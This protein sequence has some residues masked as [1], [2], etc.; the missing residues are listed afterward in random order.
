MAATE[1]ATHGMAATEAS[2]HGMPTTEAATHTS[3]A[4]KGEG[5]WCKGKQGGER[6]RNQVI[7]EPVAHRRILRF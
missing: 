4:S 2:S 7:C 3:T 6:T 5:R 1:A